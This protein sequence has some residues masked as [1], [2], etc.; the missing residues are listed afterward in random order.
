MRKYE[1]SQAYYDSAINSLPKDYEGYAEIKARQE[2][3]DEFVKNLNTIKWQDS[4]LVF[5]NLDS[6]ATRMK[7]D[8]SF[9]AKK[10]LEEANAGKKKRKK[11]NRIEIVSNANS[12][13]NTGDDG[14]EETTDWYFGN[15]SAMSLGQSEFKRIWGNVPLEDNWRRSLRYTAPRRAYP[16]S[17]EKQALRVATENKGE[18]AAPVDPVAA[19]YDRISSQIPRTEEQKKQALKLIEDAYYNLG[20][21]YYF[22]LLEKENAVITYNQL[23]DRFP[24]TEYEPEILYKLYLLQ[25]N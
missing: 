8:S 9:Q 17:W 12:V 25:G 7:I 20:D 5:A 4:L 13:F 15:L 1:L 24:E 19:E 6:A 16:K 10:A 11:S 22:K 21:I 14:N 3:L 18:A 2:I 23:L